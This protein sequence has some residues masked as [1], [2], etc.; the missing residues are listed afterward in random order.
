MSLFLC[1]T[2]ITRPAACGRSRRTS[3]SSGSSARRGGLEEAR[4][5]NL[6]RQSHRFC[7]LPCEEANAAFPPGVPDRRAVDGSPYKS[8]KTH[9][10]VPVSCSC[11]PI[12]SHMSGADRGRPIAADPGRCTAESCGEADRG[13][14]SVK[15]P[16]G[17]RGACRLQVPVPQIL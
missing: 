14:A 3:F 2:P 11:C 10:L 12:T 1:H 9:A 5:V 16:G 7:L 13:C 4:L 15:D 17:N 8:R 6:E